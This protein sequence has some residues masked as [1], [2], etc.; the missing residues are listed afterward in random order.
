M[1]LPYEYQQR[2]NETSCEYKFRLIADKVDK[3][4]DLDWAEIREILGLEITPDTLRKQGQGIREVYRFYEDKQLEKSIA[5]AITDDT[6]TKTQEFFKE[7]VKFQDQKREYY[8]LLRNQARF[9][10]LRDEIK[11]AIDEL[12]K[13]KPLKFNPSYVNYMTEDVTGVTLWSDWHYGMFVDHEFN[14]YDNDIFHNRVQKLV[15]K[16]KEYGLKNKIKKL[17]IGILGDNISGEIHISTKVQNNE[18]VIRQVQIVSETIAEATE[19]LANTFEEVEL[20]FVTGNHGRNGKKDEV[21]A[22]DNFEYLIPWYLESRL[23]QFTNVTITSDKDT[24]VLKHIHN[25]PCIFVHGNYDHVSSVAKNLPHML[26]IIPSYIFS[27]HIHHNYEREQ[28]RTTVVA[29]G[30]LIGM[31]DYSLQK[32]LYATPSQKFMIMNNDGVECTYNIK[33]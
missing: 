29:N 30:S 7:K 10:H 15:G 1:T 23:K 24:Y 22:K 6:E 8:N 33:L 31:D 9:E 11:L 27:G 20:I 21:T 26:G 14:K 17:I 25:Q 3:I 28:G 4:V 18:N 32:R 5:N 13:R 2:E 12:A 19:Q 16:V